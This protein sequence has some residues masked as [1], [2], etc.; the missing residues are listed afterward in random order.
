MKRYAVM[1]IDVMIKAES[2][3]RPTN[4]IYYVTDGINYHS[5]FCPYS[6]VGRAT[7]LSSRL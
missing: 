3:G 4:T 7:G 5:L 1:Q 2:K 6:S